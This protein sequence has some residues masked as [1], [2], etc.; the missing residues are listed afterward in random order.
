MSISKNKRTVITTS[1]LATQRLGAKL[2]R[3]LA[4][5]DIVCLVGE[6]GA[7]KTCLVK[8][9]ARGLA[10]KGYV[11]SPTFK[12]INEYQ[13]KWPVYHFD[14]YRLADGRQVSELGYE[15]Y[16]YGRG[17]TLIEWAE[18]IIPLL[19]RQYLKINLKRIDEHTRKIELRDWRA[20]SK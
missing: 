6:L 8:G 4:P 11:N 7:G 14:L 18:K 9:L 19:P 3:T 10:V 17:V 2:A 1:A 12:L 5:G 15:E 20:K 16:L 13:G